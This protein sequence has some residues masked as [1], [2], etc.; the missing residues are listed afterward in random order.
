MHCQ[1]LKTRRYPACGKLTIYNGF[2]QRVCLFNGVA[3]VT[4]VEMLWTP[5][6]YTCMWPDLWK[7]TFIMHKLDGFFEVWKS[8]NFMHLCTWKGK[9]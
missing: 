5:L 3:G 1:Y 2:Y 4:Q 8:M 7:G 6:L 9:R